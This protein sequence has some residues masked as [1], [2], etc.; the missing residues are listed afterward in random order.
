MSFRRM[1][2]VGEICADVPEQ[3][4]KRAMNLESIKTARGWAAWQSAIQPASSSE[5]VKCA[6]YVRS[7]YVRCKPAIQAAY[8]KAMI[9]AA[10]QR[11][12][13]LRKQTVKQLP[14]PIKADIRKSIDDALF[15][16]STPAVKSLEL[17]YEVG[18]PFL[19]ADCM[20]ENEHDVLAMEFRHATGG[21]LHATT[22]PVWCSLKG[23]QARDF[24]AWNFRD[25]EESDDGTLA[26]DFLT[27]LWAASVN[28]QGMFTDVFVDGPIT[29]EGECERG[30]KLVG[31][32]QGTPTLGSELVATLRD[33][34]KITKAEVTLIIGQHPFSGMVDNTLAFRGVRLPLSVENDQEGMFL[35]RM[36]F[37][38]SWIDSFYRIVDAYIAE[39]RD[40]A[41]WDKRTRS[42]RTLLQEQSVSPRA[43]VVVT[44]EVP[45]PDATRGVSPLEIVVDMDVKCTACGKPGATKSGRCLSCLS[46]ISEELVTAA[47]D[48]IK[49][50]QRASVSSI[51]RRLR[52]G[53]SMAANIMDL[54]EERGMVGPA[55]GSKPREIL[56]PMEGG[57]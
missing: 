39:R 54:L 41:A 33:G 38:G 5:A 16:S 40:Q 56:M 2:I 43:K 36:V 42:I 27:W 19:L 11:E 1:H 35:E 9:K 4:C 17:A 34:K 50:T 24:H 53:Y 21:L 15:A 23:I 22:I 6:G 37:A 28:G 57:K 7:Q 52:I 48:I 14:K 20:T 8:R 29:L 49:E 45:A 31:L 13:A 46:Q 3:L 18:K 55:L 32:K 51:Q 47:V 12:A 44:K 26:D 10:F 30:P 25:D